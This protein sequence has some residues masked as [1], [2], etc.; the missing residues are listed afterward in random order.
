MT[1]QKIDQPVTPAS[2]LL[3]GGSAGKPVPFDYKNGENSI[4]NNFDKTGSR[5]SR[6]SRSETALEEFPGVFSNEQQVLVIDHLLKTNL[7]LSENMTRK[8]H[9]FAFYLLNDFRDCWKTNNLKSRKT[10]LEIYCGNPHILSNVK[11]SDGSAT[12][13]ISYM[14]KFDGLFVFGEKREEGYRRIRTCSLG[15]QGKALFKKVSH[16]EHCSGHPE[17][18]TEYQRDV[19]PVPLNQDGIVELERGVIPSIVGDVYSAYPQI[20]EQPF[21]T[22]FELSVYKCIERRKLTLDDLYVLPWLMSQHEKTLKVSGWGRNKE[23]TLV[24]CN[25]RS[26]K[27]LKSFFDKISILRGD[28]ESIIEEECN[29]WDSIRNDE[30]FLETFLPKEVQKLAVY[31]EGH[32]HNEDNKII[33]GIWKPS[34]ESLKYKFFKL[35]KSYIDGRQKLAAPKA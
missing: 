27:G 11:I 26:A 35:Y 34:L 30:D 18:D 23:P 20:K 4:F 24:N 21:K 32:W 29:V 3:I 16:L 17:R 2:R 22:A 28:Y 9:C 5:R 1:N 12:K 25:L 8:V 15:N 6:K 13:Y 7:G 14:K 19:S 10:K 31:L 33:L